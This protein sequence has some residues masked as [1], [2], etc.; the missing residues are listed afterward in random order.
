MTYPDRFYD[1]YR[2]RNASLFLEAASTL[3][4][5]ADGEQPVFT[6]YIPKGQTPEKRIWMPNQ[7][8]IEVH[9]RL[10]SALEIERPLFLDPSYGGITGGSPARNI[11]P[12]TPN[13]YFYQLDFANAYSQ[14]DAAKLARLIIDGRGTYKEIEAAQAVLETYCL[15]PTGTG[16]AR[17]G[18]LSPYLFNLYCEELDWEL[19]GYTDTRGI[20]YTRYLDDLTF[21]RPDNRFPIRDTITAP[22]RADIRTIIEHNGLTLNPAKTRVS[23]VHDAPVIITGLQLDKNGQWHIKDKAAREARAKLLAQHD[24]F[25]GTLLQKQV[26]DLA[27]GY[28]GMVDAAEHGKKRSKS[29]RQLGELAERLLVEI[30]AL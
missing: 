1:R 15:A 28:K 14:V 23:D 6:P 12:H 11:A 7:A 24:M 17:G 18:P 16:L 8:M 29:E 22:E 26:R 21:S 3:G 27:A 13:R 4:E 20:T 19:Q 10:K 5:F 2:P 9:G 30:P 25:T